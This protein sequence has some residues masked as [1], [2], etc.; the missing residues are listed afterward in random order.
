[1]AEYIDR[2]NYCKSVCRCSRDKCDK[3]KCP[4]WAA[5]A[6]DPESLPIVQELRAEL[7]NCKQELRQ[8]KYCYDIA[9]NGEK[10]LRKQN[11]E[12]T[13]AWAEC[14]KKLKQVTEERDAAVADMQALMWHSGD[15]CE[16]C[17]HKIVEQRHPYT[18]LGC[19][20]NGE[21]NPKWCGAED[22][23]D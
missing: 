3:D 19:K 21:C 9:K 22:K 11:D 8:I 12:I 23:N 7:A 20:L 17:G 16:I 10:Q 6:I 14:A 15:G 5:P 4:L 13:A 18:R 2:E 1:M